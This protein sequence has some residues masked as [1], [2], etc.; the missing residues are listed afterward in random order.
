MIPCD[1]ISMSKVLAVYYFLS[2]PIQVAISHIKGSLR[3]Q[4]G[5]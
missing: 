2:L 1:N 5:T 4:T 3:L